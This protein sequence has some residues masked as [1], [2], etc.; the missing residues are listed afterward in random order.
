MARKKPVNIKDLNSYAGHALGVNLAQTI[1][2]RIFAVD[3]RGNLRTIK[4]EA[5]TQT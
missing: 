1:N 3:R 5:L 4:A 2:G